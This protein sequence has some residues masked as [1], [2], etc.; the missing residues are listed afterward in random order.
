[1]DVADMVTAS[2]NMAERVRRVLPSDLN[3]PAPTTPWR[4]SMAAG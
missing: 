4:P 3:P 2:I 1:M